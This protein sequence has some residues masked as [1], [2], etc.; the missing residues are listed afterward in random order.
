MSKSVN[1]ST[2]STWS[3]ISYGEHTIS[4]IAKGKMY[5]DSDPSI[6]K[7]TKRQPE[8]NITIST[9]TNATKT[10]GPDVVK[11]GESA[12]F[13]FTAS[14]DYK[15]SSDQAIAVTL[16]PASLDI[17]WILDDTG[18]T[19]TL[20]INN[21]TSNITLAV[22]ATIELEKETAPA[23]VQIIDNT[24]TWTNVIG[25]TSYDIYVDNE[26]FENVTGE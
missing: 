26:F 11:D 14:S 4:V 13:V 22:Q 7:F 18:K 21:V 10:S 23:N 19:G 3:N 9:L 25:V 20:T 17:T 8:H 16:S 1:L 24:V 5:K 15:F 2:I 12:T 6:L